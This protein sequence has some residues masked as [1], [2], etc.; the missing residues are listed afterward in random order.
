MYNFSNSDSDEDSNDYM[1]GSE[2]SSINMP[3]SKGNNRPGHQKVVDPYNYDFDFD[4]IKAPTKEDMKKK[5]APAKKGVQS[6]GRNIFE[7]SSSESL[8]KRGKKGAKAKFE[9]SSSE[10]LPKAKVGKKGNNEFKKMMKNLG[11]PSSSDSF[12]SESSELDKKN[13]NNYLLSENSEDYDDDSS[14]DLK[15]RQPPI[16]LNKKFDVPVKDLKSGKNEKGFFK[17]KEKLGNISPLSSSMFNSSEIGSE[18]K[19]PSNDSEGS[20]QKMTEKSSNYKKNSSETSNQASSTSLIQSNIEK[21]DLREK[22]SEN[23]SFK[24]Q[25]LNKFGKVSKLQKTD[26]TSSEPSENTENFTENNYDSEHITENQTEK[27]TENQSEYAESHSNRF[28]DNISNKYTE[29][30]SDIYSDKFDEYESQQLQDSH[31]GL[32]RPTE[33]RFQRPEKVGETIFKINEVENEDESRVIRTPQTNLAKPLVR[34]QTTN[35]FLK[36]RERELEIELVD[37]RRLVAN[38]ESELESKQEQLFYYEKR[39]K[40]ANFA[41][42]EYEALEKAK[43]QLREA[44]HKIEI[45]KIET[46]ELIKQVDFNE[47]RA[48]DL[49]G[50]NNLLKVELEKKEKLVEERIKL[51]ESRTSERLIKEMTRQFEL[52][53]EDFLRRRNDLEMELTRTKTDLAKLE[54]ENRELRTKVFS[55]RDNE[56]KIKDLEHQIILLTNKEPSSEII[57]KVK[58][59]PN[60]QLRKELSMQDQLIAGFQRENEKLTQEVRKLKMQIKDEQLKMHH[61]AKKVDLLKSNL[62]R[63]HGGVLIKENIS[64]LGSINEL[65][66]GTVINKEEYLN[67][68]DNVARLTRE[69]M[70]KER[71]YREKELEYCEQIENLRKVKFESEY[72]LTSMQRSQAFGVEKAA[73]DKFEQEK[74]EIIERFEREAIILNDKIAFLS[75]NRPDNSRVKILEDHIR[76]LEEALK[77]K[78]PISTLIKAVKPESSDQ[79]NFLSKKVSELEEKLKDKKSII[80]SVKKGGKNITKTHPKAADGGLLEKIKDLEKQLEEKNYYISKLSSIKPDSTEELKHL[81]EQALNYE[82]VIKNMEKHRIPITFNLFPFM[83]SYSGSVWCQ[84]CQEV[85]YLKSQITQKNS[86]ELI[87]ISSKLIEL[88]ESTSSSPEFSNLNAFDRILD[89]T[90]S[91]FSLLKGIPN[92]NSLEKVHSE[93]TLILTEEL[94]LAWQG[95]PEVTSELEE[96]YWSDFSDND[97]EQE[98]NEN[99]ESLEVLGKIKNGIG[100]LNRIGGGWLALSQ[101]QEILS[102][103]IPELNTISLRNMLRRVSGPGGKINI[104]QFL[105]DVKEININQWEERLRTYLW[106]NKEKV[107]ARGNHCSFVEKSLVPWIVEGILEK[108]ENYVEK[109]GIDFDMLTEQ[110]FSGSLAISKRNFRIKVLEHKLPLTRE[111]CHVLVKELD[112]ANVGQINAKVFLG[113]IKRVPKQAW[114]AK[115]TESFPEYKQ[116]SERDSSFL[117]IK[118]NKRIAELEMHLRNNSEAK[119]NLNSDYTLNLKLKTIEEELEMVKSKL[120]SVTSD[121][122]KLKLDKIRLENHINKQSINVGASEYL[123]LQRKIEIIEDN[124][125]RREQEM[126]N[127]MNGMSYKN[128]QEIIE[129]KK[130]SENE[131]IQMQRIIQKKNNEIQEFKVE[132]EELLKEIELLRAK[133]RGK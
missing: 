131:K 129:L 112:K 4:N 48:R 31:P 95:Q 43:T 61:E 19:K 22:F 11:K 87:Q 121:N 113:F 91:M 85:G 52:D 94:N 102:A 37:L 59:S 50:E 24:P 97:Q 63:D 71:F 109:E 20:N 73:E 110:L 122:E 62:I 114:Q 21:K 101:V 120:T 30:Q 13:K 103:N 99:I 54:G 49:E 128:D 5:P 51:T 42:V 7:E 118:A 92:W 123:A 16:N 77:Q 12:N 36:T 70:E 89:K 9:Y 104:D 75:Q 115:P 41:K 45:Y 117:L 96:E 25:E 124:H 106:E 67:L 44:F 133:R 60:D 80:P 119:V 93:L 2:S 47:A 127:M 8:P 27:Y 6:K 125:Y 58:E 83:S 10:S 34:P 78:E 130:K 68:K 40:Q 35:D 56:E 15:P 76:S 46:E 28:P 98:E 32:P 81:R 38:L 132:L 26:K 74:K 105:K 66:G 100:Y 29:N 3:I 86:K 64:D 116:L 90:L 17:Q 108:I 111:E 107:S 39:D 69:L 18:Y 88:L 55:F 57:E 14:E 79:V 33:N 23:F 65:A 1:S 126:R 53:K 72:L 84:I 82:R